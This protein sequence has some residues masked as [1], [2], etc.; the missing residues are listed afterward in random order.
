MSQSGLP[1]FDFAQVLPLGMCFPA[2][3]TVLPLGGGQLAL[4]SPIPIDDALGA[5]LARL[6]EV[7]YLIA[8]NLLHHLY[9]P[10]ACQRY[11]EARVLAPP[12]LLRKRPEL[13]IDL[14]LDQ[15]LPAELSAAVEVI[16]LAGAPA[17]SEYAFY[18]RP[19]RTLVL[20][21]LVF[22][23]LS[24]EG[25]L[26]HL[27]LWLGGCHRRLAASRFW[28]MKLRDRTAFAASV[29]SLLERP[30]DSL[31]MAHGEP[32]HEQ[33]RPRL[34]SALSWALPPRAALAAPS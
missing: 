16:A 2:R 22:H 30:F 24:P 19:A 8:P 27:M 5:Q 25:W 4:V 20:T 26:A 33:A 3:M 23:V 1:V 21:D 29:Q 6:G 28:R 11:P 13:R 10:A 7:R 34:A 15:P 17:I 9:L 14:T 18:H 32:I 12:G 31:V